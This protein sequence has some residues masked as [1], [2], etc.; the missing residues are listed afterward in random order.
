M[1]N[2]LKSLFGK[3]K[4]RVH[5]LASNGQTGYAKIPY[6]GEYDEEELIRQFKKAAL[7]E[8]GLKIVSVRVVARIV[9]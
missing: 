9:E 3:G 7:V 8:E 6:V 2:W 4:V 1:I 5:F